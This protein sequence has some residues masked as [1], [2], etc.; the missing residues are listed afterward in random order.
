MHVSLINRISSEVCVFEL[1][2]VYYSVPKCLGISFGEVSI[3][4]AKGFVR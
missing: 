1:V 2:F 3:S 4:I